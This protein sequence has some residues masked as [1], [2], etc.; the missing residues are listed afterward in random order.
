MALLNHGEAPVLGRLDAEQRAVRG[1]SAL[2]DLGDRGVMRLVGADTRRFCNSM[3]TND[4]RTLGVGHGRHNAMTDNK[5]RLMGLLDGWM[6]SAESALLV[7][8][9][10]DPEDT[11]DRL[12]M[13]IIMDPIE[14][15]RLEHS[16]GVLHLAGPEAEQALVGLGLPLP[17]AD[18][19]ALEDGWVL[20][21]ERLGVPG[22]DLVLPLAHAQE[23]WNTTSLVRAGAEA[24]DGLR[25]EQGPRPC[26]CG[27]TSAGGMLHRRERPRY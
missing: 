8:D 13:Y 21:N 22:F 25:I 20:R 14:L 18:V 12:D 2:F 6:L 23:L 10:M 24:F 15:T 26:L 19:A 3:F 4:W 5:G 11:Y 9:G 1:A 17:E 27:G 16:H 7:L